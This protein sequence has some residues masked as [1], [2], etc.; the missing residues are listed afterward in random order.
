MFEHKSQPLLHPRAYVQRLARST[1]AG[2][3]L[4]AAS[5]FVGM[6]GYHALEHL[7]WIDAFFTPSRVRRYNAQ[8]AA[9]IASQILGSTAGYIAPRCPACGKPVAPTAI[10]CSPAEPPPQAATTSTLNPPPSSTTTAKERGPTCGASLLAFLH[11][12]NSQAS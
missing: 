4:I 10:F 5:L 6:A 3:A 9:Y 7:G 1:A 11:S 8:Q 12:S 2:L